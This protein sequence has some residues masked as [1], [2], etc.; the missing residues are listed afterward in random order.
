MQ[1]QCDLSYCIFQKWTFPV[2][3]RQKGV[4]GE[5]FPISINL[6]EERVHMPVNI[7]FKFTW[8]TKL[9]DCDKRNK[10]CPIK[11]PRS[12]WYEEIPRQV[13]INTGS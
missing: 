3:K 13:W 11:D 4:Y 1:T 5:T 9:D 12:I 8:T 7:K 10:D 2:P 6:R